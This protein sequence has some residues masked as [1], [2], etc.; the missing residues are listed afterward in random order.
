VFPSKRLLYVDDAV[1]IDKKDVDANGR[2]GLA[3]A[4]FFSFSTLHEILESGKLDLGGKPDAGWK[5]NSRVVSAALGQGRHVELAHPARVYL[6][7]LVPD[8]MT[9]AI[10]VY[11]D[12]EAHGWSNEGCKVVASNST[13]TVCECNHLTNFAVV[14]RPATPSVTQDLLTSVRLDIVAYVIASVVTLAL[15]VLLVRVRTINSSEFFLCKQKVERKSFDLCKKN[16]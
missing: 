12:L 6:R 10:C 4:V 13:V 8:N 2:E 5:L 11:W 7:H 9:D 1:E 16:K 14:M 15:F 3:E